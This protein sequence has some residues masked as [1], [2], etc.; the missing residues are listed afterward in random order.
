MQQTIRTAGGKGN[1][2]PYA[3]CVLAMVLLMP[4]W[5][6][7][8][9][10]RFQ[11]VIGDVRVI[12]TA[13]RERPVFKGVEVNEG[14]TIVSAS[15]GSAQ[16]VLIDGGLM[17]IR[18][19]TR[20]R[21][22]AFRYNGKEDGTEKGFFSLLK[23]TFRSVT[24]A[25]GRSN[26]HAYAIKTPTATI[27]IRG[28]DHEPMFIPV[29]LAGEQAIGEP[30]TYD[31]VNEG[32]AYIETARG[33]T[34]VG[35]NQVG[36]ARDAQAVP[37]LLP[38]MPEFFRTHHGRGEGRPGADGRGR[39]A[40]GPGVARLAG[41]V[42]AAGQDGVPPVTGV[43]PA[44]E[45]AV[46]L[47]APVGSLPP[48]P[49]GTTLGTVLPPPPPPDGTL[50]PTL[51][52]VGTATYLPPPPPPPSYDSSG[53]LNV[54]SPGGTGA[55]DA[56][57]GSVGIGAD[58]S[59]FNGRPE[60]GSGTLF[61]TGGPDRVAK[62]GPGGALVFAADNSDGNQ[63]QYSA[64]QARLVQF[65]SVTHAATGISIRWGRWSGADV[66]Y[67]AMRGPRDPAGF[68]FMLAS[69]H[70]PLTSLPAVFSVTR[71]YGNISLPHPNVI[72]FTHPTDQTGTAGTLT[73]ALVG[74]SG[75]GQITAVS[76]GGTVP[77]GTWS[78]SL[79]TGSC[80]PCS[81]TRLFNNTGP[82]VPLVGSIAGSGA[83]GTARGAFVGP[84]AE[85]L[86]MGYSLSNT[87]NGLAGTV[88]V[89]R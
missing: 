21:I 34:V 2:G 44:P 65:S 50:S 36:F 76:L 27:G 80:A 49:E 5:A 33:V 26:K 13:G 12:D 15:G 43:A 82:G 62:L 45:G 54:T 3:M 1:F 39:H 48:P 28:T 83:S 56:P 46:P 38:K 40:A 25:V 37:Q 4:G 88:A 73:Q 7:A 53:G 41:A 68:H 86:L 63:F 30:G 84:A 24:G 47:L 58:M 61:V 19:D 20:L 11:F 87:S 6:Q 78:A 77:A 59:F 89:R 60:G 16:L 9:A 42:R 51:A 81:F 69:D 10:G 18:P 64:G 57:I 23:G 17:A 70:T 55:V 29:P 52:P 72:G 14:E 79:N 8:A 71:V 35:P 22:D 32:S 74:I 31:K 67:D 66:M 85:V 75:S